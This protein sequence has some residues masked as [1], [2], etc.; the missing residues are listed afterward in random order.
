MTI[1][2]FSREQLEEW[3]LPGRGDGVEVLHDEQVDSGRWL[4]YH[5][6]VF[7]APDDGKTYQ[8]DYQQ[9]L[10]EIQEDH[11]RWN[12]ESEIGGH[13]VELVEVVTKEWRKVAR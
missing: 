7:R 2:V 13:E 12:Y 10:T 9:G 4:A 6:L 8:V 11:D 1:R 5:E 3:D